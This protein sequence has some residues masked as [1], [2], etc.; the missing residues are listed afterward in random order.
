MAAPADPAVPSRPR[1]GAD[2]L[3]GVDGVRALAALM[4]VVY[5]S[6]FFASW[7]ETWGGSILWNLNAGVWIFF[8]L[9]G[10]LLYRPFAAAHLGG[11]GRARLGAYAVRRA[12]R[13]YPAY[14][15]ALAFFAW[16]VPRLVI[17]GSTGV[18]RHVLLLQT[19]LRT[20]AP[21]GPFGDGLP[22]AW[23]LVVE[24]TFY[25]F[26]PLYAAAVGV[27]ARWRS[28]VRVEWVGVAT[29]AVVGIAATARVARGDAPAWLTIL[30]QHLPA[31]AAGIALAVMSQLPPGDR[32][33]R[34]ATAIGARAGL[35]WSAA[36]GVFLVIPF[37]LRIRP[38]VAPGAPRAF[39]LDLALTVFAAC[40]VSPVALAGGGRGAIGRG[41]RSRP[42]V[43]LGTISY[44]VFLWHWFVLLVVQDDWLG[45]PIGEA[46]WPVV[47]V[48]ALPLVIAAATVSWFALE[49]P[50]LRAAHAVTGV[51]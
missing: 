1:S 44:G 9:S 48:L 51:R 24:V 49:R 32:I 45:R 14:W 2:R 37:G 17:D 39:L 23:S 13:I 34:R 27:A 10:F 12:A 47:F 33:A 21:F 3:L 29:L 16:V 40:V 22:P 11:G 19:Y 38:F 50:V 42:A 8:V 4:V 7:F 28:P 31:F 18:W 36:L 46:A 41:L 5:H 26:L 20:D 15:L 25:A 35:W 43:A 30:P 6:V